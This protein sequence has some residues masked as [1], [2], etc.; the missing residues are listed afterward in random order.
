MIDPE[1]LSDNDIGRLLVWEVA[2]GVEERG[3]LLAWAEGVIVIA[4]PIPGS[5]YMRPV[6]VAPAQVRWVE[7]VRKA[8]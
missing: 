2:P 7:G 6:E 8:G 5:K 3:Q 4:L 1:T